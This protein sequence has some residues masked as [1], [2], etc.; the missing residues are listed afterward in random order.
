MS[1]ITEQQ[2]RQRLV[3]YDEMVPCQE[4]FLDR[5]ID[6]R[7]GNE[8]FTI[9]GPGVAESADQHVHISIPHGFNIGG[10]RQV[11][12]AVNSQHSH[13]T[14]EVFVVHSG[15][16]KFQTGV[17]GEDAEIELE[18]GD[19]ISVPTHVFRG[20]ENV[21]DQPAYLFAVLGGDDPGRVTWAPDV[22]EK[23][24]ETG[25]VL[26]EDGSLID[27][28]R[29]EKIPD[30]VAPMPPTTATQAAQFQRISA[31]E[32]RRCIQP[33]GDMPTAGE[34]LLTRGTAVAE[35]PI[36]GAECPDEGLPAGQM[37][38]PHGFSLRCLAFPPGASIALHSRSEVEVLFVH[39]GRLE[40]EWPNGRL[41]LNAGDVLSVPE[42]LEHAFSN[43]GNE[44]ASVYVVR[45][46]DRPGPPRFVG[47]TRQGT[48][49]QP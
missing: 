28:N 30:G 14:A 23:A 20:F 2:M 33:A 32:L 49:E 47:D 37:D 24:R 10:A 19:T 17:E 11:P 18:P 22:F 13:D 9:I 31:D 46:A 43:P 4:A 38:W 36:I 3:R 44:N 35:C 21:S 29:G 15:R 48:S 34:S 42:E 7:G 27:T 45:R 5:R 41:Q 8:N 6:Q 40:I 1:R 25:L 16:W 26:L 39:A 12:H